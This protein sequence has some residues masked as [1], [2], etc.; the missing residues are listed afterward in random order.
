MISVPRVRRPPTPK[1]KVITNR[2]RRLIYHT[3]PEVRKRKRAWAAAYRRAHPTYMKEYNRKYR[4]R[5]QRSHRVRKMYA[6]YAKILGWPEGGPTWPTEPLLP[7]PPGFP[8][9]GERFKQEMRV[10][11]IDLFK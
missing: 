11:L 2:A 1:E 9:I 5:L 8:K 7:R 10:L 6:R 4:R 3:D